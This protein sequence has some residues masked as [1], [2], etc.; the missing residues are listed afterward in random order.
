MKILIKVLQW[1][2]LAWFVLAGMLILGGMIGI[3]MQDG[4]IEM[5]RMYGPFDL[6]NS[7][8][9]ALTFA[10]AVAA[11]KWADKLRSKANI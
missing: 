10:P 4:F 7:V 6:A 11:T 2:S 5:L 3:W 8:I 9:I 1:F